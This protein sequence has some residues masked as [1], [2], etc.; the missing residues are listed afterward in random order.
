MS[1]CP[2]RIVDYLERSEGRAAAMLSGLVRIPT[3]NPYSGD[4]RPSGEAA[5][6]AFAAKRMKELGGQTRFISVPSDVYS[7]AGM[8]GPRDREWQGRS[9]LV[10]RFVFGS[11]GRKIVLNA[12]MDT[13]GVDGYRG[14]P[15]DGR[16]EDGVIYGRG[17]SDC[18]SGVIAGLLAIEA[19][20]KTGAGLDC[21]IL[22]E[23]VVDEE[24]NGGGAGTLACCFDGV[25]GDYC[26]VLDGDAKMVYP[27]CQGICTADIVVEGRAGHG[28]LGGVSAIEK[29]LVVKDAVDR[30]VAERAESRPGALVNIGVMRA[31]TAP[32]TVA[33]HGYLSANVNY[34]Y[35]EARESEAAGRGFSGAQ[36]RE[37]LEALVAEAAATD[38]WL[39]ERPPVLVWMKDVPPFRMSDAGNQ[40]ECERLLSITS[41]AY[42]R[43]WGRPPAV[44]E[45]PAWG[46]AA[47]LA[48]IGRMPTV[49]MGAGE[50][51]TAHTFSEHNRAENVTRTAAATAIAVLEL[52][53]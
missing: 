41:D 13:I 8:I 52:A 38:D 44:K 26:I 12:H 22:F 1:V 53:K 48:R 34:T 10:G 36:V 23:T 18:K 20:Q 43:S 7:R 31:G 49:G 11:G 5:G 28:S 9:C 42:A 4:R 29:M 16:I 30:L 39:R 45:L 40:A 46:D 51:G 14:D 21:E 2:D 33:D 6:Q 17:S 50:A 25:L 37:R 15:F 35:D 19:L 47:H 24:C 3:V 27:G 32:W